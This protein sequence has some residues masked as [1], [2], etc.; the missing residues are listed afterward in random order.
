VQSYIEVTEKNWRLQMHSE[1]ASGLLK[2]HAARSPNDSIIG[3][4]Q[5][6]Q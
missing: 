5:A 3:L 2:V 6:K 1:V 4:S